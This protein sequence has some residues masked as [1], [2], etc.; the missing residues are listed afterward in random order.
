VLLDTGRVTARVPKLGPA[1]T[2]AVETPEATVLVH[3]TAFSV[4]RTAPSAESAPRTIVDVGEGTVAV[5]HHGIEVLLHACDHWSSGSSLPS[6]LESAPDIDPAAGSPDRGA[7]R[8]KSSPPAHRTSGAPAKGPEGISSDKSSNLAA[9]NRLLQAAM[10]ARQQ[11]DARRAVQLAGEL[12]TRFP[13][14]PLVEEARVE[15]MRALLG[16]SGAAAAA[17][18][19]RS[20][21]TDYPAGFARQEANRIVAGAAR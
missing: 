2:F 11:G 18:E 4:E 9:E 14:S 17:A 3:G 7:S 16:A 8:P 20:Y 5:R 12:V 6:E 19:A 1:R 10:A 21:L 13:G 15:R